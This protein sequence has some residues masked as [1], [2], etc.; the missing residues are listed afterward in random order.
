LFTL[1]NL[2]T[3]LRLV[4]VGPIVW[5]SYSLG[6]S[7]LAAAIVLFTVAAISDWLDGALARHSGTSTTFGILMD[8]LVDKVMILS[9]LIVFVDRA[10]LPLWLVLLNVLRELSVTAVR[11]GISSRTKVF[12]A[13]WMGKTK[14]VLQV[15][16]LELGYV[17]LLFQSVQRDFPGGTLPVFWWAVLVTAV[18]YAFLMVFLYQN[19]RQLLPEGR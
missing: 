4:S 9:V 15:T 6:T 13:N 14:F 2:I 10:I 17:Y 1:P 8:P 3:I 11:L 7:G 19:R 5:L 12:G 16:V 18:S